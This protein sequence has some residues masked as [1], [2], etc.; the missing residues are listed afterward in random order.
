MIIPWHLAAKFENA[1][2]FIT[3]VFAVV[4]WE[5]KPLG[6]ELC[7]QDSNPSTLACPMSV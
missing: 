2:K 4:S 3:G 7:G 6:S 5:D 1:H